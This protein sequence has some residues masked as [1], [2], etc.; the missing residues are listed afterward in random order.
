MSQSGCSAETGLARPVVAVKFVDERRRRLGGRGDVD[1]G[2][3]LR[4]SPLSFR[5]FRCCSFVT[6]LR[7]NLR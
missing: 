4:F 1:V 5:N 6:L 3:R 2:D 7:M